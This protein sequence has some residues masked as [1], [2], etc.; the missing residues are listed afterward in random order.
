M[1]PTISGKYMIFRMRTPI[2]GNAFAI[3][4]VFI[5]RAKRLGKILKIKT[6]LGITTITPTKYLQQAERIEMYKYNPNVPM[7][8]YK[9]NLVP[10][11]EAPQ[12]ELITI[13][14]E[15]RERLREIAIEKGWYKRAGI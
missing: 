9:L 4:D 5:Y 14:N 8:M 2:Y 3:R 13:P 7:I 15:A 6:P 12:E 1:K 11:K 10:D